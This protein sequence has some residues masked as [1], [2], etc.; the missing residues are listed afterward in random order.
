MLCAFVQDWPRDLFFL[1]CSKNSIHNSPIVSNSLF[2]WSHVHEK[3]KQVRPK[4]AYIMSTWTQC[5]LLVE[6][7]EIKR[8]MLL[9]RGE[10]IIVHIWIVFIGL[11]ICTQNVGREKKGTMFHF[12]PKTSKDISVQESLFLQ[13]KTAATSNFPHLKGLT[14]PLHIWDLQVFNYLL[15]AYHPAQCA[16]SI[17]AHKIFIFSRVPEFQLCETY[18]SESRLHQK[19]SRVR[20]MHRHPRFLC[21]F[22]DGWCYRDDGQHTSYE[23]CPECENI[24]INDGTILWGKT[25]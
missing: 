24:Q 20:S 18:H 21:A 7:P 12:C 17:K 25:L 13:H 6:S 5:V 15:W 8:C 9:I 2:T 3:T 23:S 11:F 16:I 22:W 4:T 14:R 10:N 19:A 1:D